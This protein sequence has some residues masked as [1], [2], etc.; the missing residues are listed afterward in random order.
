VTLRVGM[1]API[2]HGYPPS[3]YGPWERVTHDLT[4]TLVETGHD[5][6]LFA[7]S[8]SVTSAELHPT[9][10]APL[11]EMHGHNWRNLEDEHIAAALCG[12][13][14][15]DVDVVHS[16]L[17]VHA[18]A[19]ERL[20]GGPLL[21]TLHGVASN[22]KVREELSK[23]ARRPFVSLSNS[24]RQFHPELNYVATIP[25]GIR[26]EEFP[27]G[28]GSGGYLA[29]VGRLAPEKAPHRA[30]DIAREAGI[31]LLMAGTIEDRY[32]DYAT[33]VLAKVG[34]GVDYLGSLERPDLAIMLAGASGL[35]MPLEWDE[36]FGLVVVESLS[37]GTPVVAWN[38]GAMPEIL[39]P[40]RT[41]FLV[42]D[43]DEA[44]AAIG[45]LKEIDRE[46]CA[47]TARQRFNRYVM[48]DAYARVYEELALNTSRR[49]SAITKSPKTRSP[50]RRNRRA[51]PDSPRG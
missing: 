24:E 3:G 1:L 30:I 44:V 9:V 11:S 6:V 12:A 45:K 15:A 43:V 33:S 20:F 34:P 39:E 14:K 17:H 50:R 29:F 2:T 16:H 36:P 4:E 26:T 46:D 28:D 31:P 13:A 47:A 25:N 32:R 40:G 5:V 27:V 48:A 38:R 8:D 7:P 10:S 35:L 19:Q 18:L 23:F 21:S 41:G 51:L 37:S 22:R 49:A 42:G